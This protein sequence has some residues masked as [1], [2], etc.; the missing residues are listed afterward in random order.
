MNDL[1]S[2]RRY[3]KMRDDFIRRARHTNQHCWLCSQPID[4]QAAKRTPQSPELDHAKPVS[5]HPHLV[6]EPTNFRI[7][8]ATCNHTR[9][10]KPAAAHQHRM[11][12]KTTAAQHDWA[13]ATW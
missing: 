1:R 13:P 11:N 12:A 4:Y 2:G 5:T 6:Y 3:R 8:H 10:A 7:A 9:G